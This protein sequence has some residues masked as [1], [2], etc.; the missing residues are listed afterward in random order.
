MN[1]EV[2]RGRYMQNTNFTKDDL[3]MDEVNVDTVMN[4]V[5]WHI[6]STNVIIE[7]SWWSSSRC[8]SR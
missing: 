3:S 5:S 2:M 6:V 4:R 8:S 7:K 1:H